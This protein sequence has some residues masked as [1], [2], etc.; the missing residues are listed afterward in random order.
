MHFFFSY[1]NIA[2]RPQFSTIGEEMGVGYQELVDNI[3]IY[4]QMAKEIIYACLDLFNQAIEQMT[5]EMPMPEVREYY[6][7][8]KKY[9]AELPRKI[10]KSL[11]PAR[12]YLRKV[13]EQMD[14]AQEKAQE[15]YNNAIEQLDL[16]TLR[17]ENAS[18]TFFCK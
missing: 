4:G 17:G 5:S 13:G 7:Q 6:R 14:K 10:A 2:P 3:E 11:E 8:M 12:D 16:Q 18:L 1:L 15:A 9:V